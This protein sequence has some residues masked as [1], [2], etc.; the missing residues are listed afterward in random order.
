[1]DTFTLMIGIIS[2]IG[3]NATIHSIDLHEKSEYLP[4]GFTVC[5]TNEFGKFRVEY[6]EETSN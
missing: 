3:D 6:S 5:G 1:M 2:A 4:K